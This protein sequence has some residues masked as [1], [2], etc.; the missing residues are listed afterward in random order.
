MSE[1]LSSLWDREAASFDEA[2]DH[3]LRDP[4]TRHAWQQLVLPLIGDPPQMIADL[5]CG[6]GSLS[7]LL[8]EAG[9]HVYGVDFSPEMLCIANHKSAASTHSRSCAQPPLIRSH[10]SNMMR[11]FVPPTRTRLHR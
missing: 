7:V 10:L 6:T 3:G 11:L 8:A 4:A 9:H 2:P 1:D 5:G